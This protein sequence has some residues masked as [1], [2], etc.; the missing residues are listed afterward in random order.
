MNKILTLQANLFKNGVNAAIILTVFILSS[1][2]LVITPLNFFIAIVA[3]AVFTF[4]LIK[5]NFC[6]YLLIFTIPFTERL[7]VLPVSFSLNDVMVFLCF[8]SV[9]INILFKKEQINLKTSIDK[10][11][12]VLLILFFYAGLTSVNSNGI[13]TS[14]KFL[15]AVIA[16][17]LTVYFVRSKQVKISKIIK[18]V[19]FSALF[20]ASLGILQSLTGQFGAFFRSPRGYLGYLGLGSNMVWHG[21]GTMGQFNTL[22]NYLVFILLF[23][24]PI[25]FYLI[26]K[27]TA[28]RLILFA[29]LLGVITTYSRGSLLGLISGCLYFFMLKTNSSKLNKYLMVALFVMLVLFAAIYLK[30]TDY[31]Q[32]VDLAGRENIWQYAIASITSSPRFLLIGAGLNSYF[33]VVSPYFPG[34]VPVGSYSLWFAHNLYLLS[35][36]EMGIIGA[37]IYFSFFITMLVTVTKRFS[38]A[39]FNLNRKLNLSVGLILVALFFVSLFDHSY[40]LTPF[41]IM[42]FIFLGLVYSTSTQ[43]KI[44]DKSY[45]K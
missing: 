39:R 29:L 18:I 21:V 4:F 41:K 43:M 9:I 25:N 40:S 16:F 26:K 42:L 37:A 20:Q 1:L 17:Y 6:Y 23:F 28:G 5:P 38:S 3:F 33:D 14:F 34:N 7:R 11:I 30:N 15:E 27:K 45:D 19:I 12:I 32:T 8:T 24:I 31:I 2:M 35:V 13:L 22:G 36:Q 10:W 44:L